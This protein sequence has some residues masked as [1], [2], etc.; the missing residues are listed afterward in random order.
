MA[1]A[2]SPVERSLDGEAGER[3]HRGRV[4]RRVGLLVLGVNVCLAL[5]KGAVW[6][7]TGSLAV[8]GEAVNSLADA[9]YSVVVLGGLYLTTRPPDF[10]HPTTSETNGSMRSWPCGCSKSGGRVVR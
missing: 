2:S 7:A 3:A 4:L 9:G 6:Y 5:A 10:E 8:G 1:D